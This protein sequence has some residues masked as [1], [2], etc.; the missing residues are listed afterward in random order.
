MEGGKLER[1]ERLML[2]II[3]STVIIVALLVIAHMAV[4]P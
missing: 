2:F 4:R 3:L 1:K